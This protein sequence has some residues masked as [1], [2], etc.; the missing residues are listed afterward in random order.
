[1]R[2]VFPLPMELTNNNDGRGHAF[3]RSNKTRNLAESLLRSMICCMRPFSSPVRIRVV[4]VLGPGQRLWD[5]SSVLRGNWKEIEDAMVAVGLL[6]DDGPKW[7]TGVI[8]EQDSSR[9]KCGPA[10]DVIFEFDQQ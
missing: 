8:G 5:F 10:V 4:R 2:I 7:V 1:M 9:R 3:W 6:H